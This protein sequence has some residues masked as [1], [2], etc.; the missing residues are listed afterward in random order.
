MVAGSGCVTVTVGAKT[1]QCSAKDGKCYEQASGCG[2]V[3]VPTIAAGSSVSIERSIL[4]IE[5][6]AVAASTDISVTLND[7]IVLDAH[8]NAF[9]QSEGSS[10]RSAATGFSFSTAAAPAAFSGLALPG[11]AVAHPVSGA[12]NVE[13][14][15]NFVFQFNRLLSESDSILSG[16]S[17]TVTPA[18]G[19]AVTFDENSTDHFTFVGDILKVSLSEELIPGMVYT[20]TLAAGSVTGAD[21]AGS[22]GALTTTFTTRNGPP[23]GG[24][25]AGVAFVVAELDNV[26]ADQNDT[27]GVPPTVIDISP[28]PGM[29][30]VRPGS[31]H[32]VYTF[33]ESVRL[34]DAANKS[35]GVISEAF[36]LMFFN[37]TNADAAQ[38]EFDVDSD[39]TGQAY[40]NTTGRT[41]SFALSDLKPDTRSRGAARKVTF[42]FHAACVHCV[43][44]FLFMQPAHCKLA[45]RTVGNGFKFQG[46][47]E[48]PGL[49]SRF[50]AHKY[51]WPGAAPMPRVRVHGKGA[52][53]IE[54]CAE[55]SRKS[56]CKPHCGKRVD[57]VRSRRWPW[58]HSA[59]EFEFGQSAF[60]H[61]VSS[62][63]LSGACKLQKRNSFCICTFS[64]VL[65]RERPPDPSAH[66][67]PPR[68][69]ADI[70]LSL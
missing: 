16:F 21:K 68:K 14:D 45:S 6:G 48:H 41:I 17:L 43:L 8:G 18:V 52:L 26:D 13:L 3:P 7:N 65:T 36:K 58:P 62:R 46:F 66:S 11:K 44:V 31:V 61:L 53:S 4:T 15:T 42:V 39:I 63:H 19:D 23:R 64:N 27:G 57:R 49:Q 24:G 5:L 25:D 30:G 10:T 37:T 9:K 60:P 70:P 28:K 51:A 20:A 22:N 67:R 40:V 55:S 35:N 69:G 56:S 12:D 34:L 29:T 32:V 33:S 54:H 1:L 38:H 2:G 59:N 47:K 50:P